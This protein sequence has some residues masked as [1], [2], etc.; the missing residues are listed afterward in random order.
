MRPG[1]HPVPWKPPNQVF[2]A[3]GPPVRLPGVWA[4]QG[5]PGSERSTPHPVPRALQG[6]S[7]LIGARR[8]QSPPRLAQ[9]ARHPVGWE[10]PGQVLLQCRWLW[11]VRGLSGKKGCAALLLR[12]PGEHPSCRSSSPELRPAACPSAGGANSTRAAGCG[13][14][15]T[16]AAWCP[17]AGPADLRGGWSW[18]LHLGLGGDGEDCE[19]GCSRRAA[20]TPQSP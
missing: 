4:L 8:G 9:S 11:P 5:S 15:L 6:P 17:G 16:W 20:S 12:A 13:W 1:S 2:A 19:R 18:L 10:Q 14:A 7:L 3:Q